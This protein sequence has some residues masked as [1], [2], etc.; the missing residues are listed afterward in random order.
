M[1]EV[2]TPDQKFIARLTDIVLGNLENENFG[3][4]DLV[5][6]SGLTLY[7]LSLRLQSVSG[8][9]V[10]QFIREVRLQKALEMLKSEEYSA[11]EVAYRV[12]FGSP[13]YFNKC[14]REFYGYSP[15]KVKKWSSNIHNRTVF[16]Q[17]TADPESGKTS[18]KSYILSWRSIGLIVIIITALAIFLNRKPNNALISENLISSDGKISLVVLP[19][20]NMTNDTL[21][22]VWQDGIQTCLI[23]SLSNTEELKVRQLETINGLLRSKG[24]TNYASIT[25]SVAGSI[26]RD[27]GASVFIRGSINQAGMEIRVNAQ[28]INSKTDEALKSFKIDGAS[29]EIMHIIDSLSIMIKNSLIISE[30]GKVGLPSYH[31]PYLKSVN[32]PEAYRFFIY[33]QNAFY[34]NDF[35]TAIDR[36]MKALAID[37]A[38]LGA[39]GK[40]SLAYYNEGNFGPAKE[41]A[42]RYFLKKDYLPLE[43]RIWAEFIHAALFKTPNERIQFMNQLQEIDDQNPL[44]YFNK[45]DGYL[46]M[47]QF[48]K[49]IPEFEKALEIFHN[50]KTK[51]FW[52]AFYNELGLAYHGAGMYREEKK[53]YRKA[54]KDF[55][56]DPQ[57]LDQA[58]G[59]AL[60]EG[61]TITANNYIEK[62]TSIR[63]E[64]SWSEAKIAGSIA[65][66]YLMA[67][68]PDKVEEYYRKA[69]SLSPDNPVFINAL[70]YILIDF[71]RNID[72]GMELLE[73]NLQKNP[74]NYASLGLK[75]WGL[76]KQGRYREARDTLQKSWDLRMERSIYNHASYLRLEAAK[77]KVF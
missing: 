61:D 70:A 48:D 65:Y 69:L 39:I 52:V 41:W 4:N 73:K 10:N 53:L 16:E 32:S 63:K 77:K 38:I 20:N 18:W 67:K 71:E 50:R 1:T 2:L 74:L 24:H 23:T 72:E 54:Q 60:T 3:V 13:A 21:W 36:F 66:I 14:F 29:G 75:G 55:P 12:G 27:L 30:L 8:K 17:K 37:S 11:S 56:D 49:A 34:N 9:T 47:D 19:F 76:Y 7:S 59:L 26:S 22:N 6:A 45:G 40:I 64:Q 25:P 42:L 15:G 43:Q 28:L 58:A 68:M 62:Y 51:P 44:T 33:G 46:E 35:P 31:E 5:K 57:I